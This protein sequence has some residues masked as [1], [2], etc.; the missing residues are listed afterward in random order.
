MLPYLASR[1]SPTDFSM[2]KSSFK[3]RK[4]KMTAARQVGSSCLPDPLCPLLGRALQGVRQDLAGCGKGCGRYLEG[5]WGQLILLALFAA[6]GQTS[7]LTMLSACCS[8]TCPLDTTQVVHRVLGT[9]GS[10]VTIISANSSSHPLHCLLSR[11]KCRWCT[12]SWAL[13]SPTQWSKATFQWQL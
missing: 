3:I 6:H 9:A 8:L 11:S 1:M 7:Y 4:A 2:A 5:D 12:V 13:Q 10:N